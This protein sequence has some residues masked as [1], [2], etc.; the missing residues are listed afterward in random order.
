MLQS[1]I[2]NRG[3]SKRLYSQANISEEQPPVQSSNLEQKIS[4]ADILSNDSQLSLKRVHQEKSEGKEE[5][6]FVTLVNSAYSMKSSEKEFDKKQ[7]EPTVFPIAEYSDFNYGLTHSN[8]MN[9][10][11]LIRE[12]RIGNQVKFGVKCMYCK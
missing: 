12:R 1:L 9:L 5:E 2:R 8:L 10:V 4:A 3:R 7:K 6:K 11:D